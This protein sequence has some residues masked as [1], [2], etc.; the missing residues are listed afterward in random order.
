L[1]EQEFNNNIGIVGEWAKATAANGIIS[2]S[3]F[4]SVVAAITISRWWIK[5]FTPPAGVA[6]FAIKSAAKAWFVHFFPFG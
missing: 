3:R 6:E 2:N 1:I 5:D 4:N